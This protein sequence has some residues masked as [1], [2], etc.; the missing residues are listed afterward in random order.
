MDYHTVYQK[1][2]PPRE[3]GKLHAGGYRKTILIHCQM[4]TVIPIS[5]SFPKLPVIFPSY[6]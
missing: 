1:N 3:G 2:I 5:I 6:E 4:Q